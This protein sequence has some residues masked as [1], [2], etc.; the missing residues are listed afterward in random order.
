MLIFLIL[1]FLTLQAV[2]LALTLRGL[3]LGKK[4]RNPL[5]LFLMRHM[6][7]VPGLVFL[8]AASLVCFYLLAI[9]ISAFWQ[10]ASLAAAS[11]LGLAVVLHNIR[12]LR[13][14]RRKV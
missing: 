13:R 10:M 9:R 14:R 12:V 8:K 4:E 6:G 5:A 3:A 11:L 2:D 7:R 1:I